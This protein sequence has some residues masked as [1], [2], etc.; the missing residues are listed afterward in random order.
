MDRKEALRR[1]HEARAGRVRSG[2]PLPAARTRGYQR[3]VWPFLLLLLLLAIAAGI[4]FG[5]RF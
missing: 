2:V 5:G 3:I 1:E 4:V